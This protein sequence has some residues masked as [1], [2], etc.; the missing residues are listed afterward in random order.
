VT[1]Q[2]RTPNHTAANEES[3][4]AWDAN[5]AFW[6][7]HMGH[8]NAWH[9]E[10]VRPATER[11]LGDP[12]GK[13][14]L[15]VGCG[16]GLLVRHL[17]SLGADALGVDISEGMLSRARAYQTEHDAR[18]EYR[19]LDCTDEGA[20]R[21]L[22][23]AQ[24]DGAVA[25]MVLMDMAE[26]RPLFRGLAHVLKPGALFVF[27]V[28]HP[29]FNN[30]AMRV[31]AEQDGNTGDFSYSVNVQR[32]LSEETRYGVAIVGQ[33]NRQPHFQRPL[34]VLLGAGFEAG[35]VLDGLEEPA[36]DA[37]HAR[38]GVATWDNLTDIPPVLVARMRRPS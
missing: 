7:E 26:I 17:A 34:H 36:F 35:F 11:L 14:I 37:S 38:P 8:G 30:A 3:R 13:R 21:E 20:I 19:H 24:F 33:P 25:T 28:L 4:D 22:G 6:D 16:N 31:L 29:A 10:L 32:Y 27:S 15:D 5:A 23:E 18:I 9:L 2:H 1:R 12:R